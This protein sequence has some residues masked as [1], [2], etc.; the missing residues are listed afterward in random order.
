[1][2][3]YYEGYKLSG[4]THL[5]EVTEMKDNQ[6]RVVLGELQ[7]DDKYFTMN[8]TD[9]WNLYTYCGTMLDLMQKEK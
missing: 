7:I 8:K 1:M 9:F 2:E 4:E 6:G 5:I 3:E